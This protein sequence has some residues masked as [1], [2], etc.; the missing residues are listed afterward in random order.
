MPPAEV[1][2]YLADIARWPEF[3]DHFLVNWRLTSEETV[4]Q[5]AGARFRIHRRLDRLQ[6]GRPRRSPTCSRAGGSSR[7]GR[8]REVQP[9]ALD[10]RRRGRRRGGRLARAAERGDRAEAADGPPHG[11]G[12]VHEALP[13]A[14]LGQ[15]DGRLRSIL[16]DGEGRGTAP[17]SPAAPAS[18]PPARPSPSDASTH[19][20]S[21]LTPLRI[22]A[23]VA[24][25]GR[26]DARAWPRSCA[27]S[28]FIR[29]NTSC[30]LRTNVRTFQI[31]SYGLDKS[32]L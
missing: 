16:E 27:A 30:A 29:L 22:A 28:Q 11:G 17:L 21:P 5:G 20:S 4:G 1:F 9:V 2:A 25:A 19:Q 31:H 24:G 18:P 8:D 14:A 26:V 32:S 15:G 3:T 13:P 12:H 6:L 7:R 10:R 23:V